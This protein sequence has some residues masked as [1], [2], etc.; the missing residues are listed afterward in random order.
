LSQQKPIIKE[1]VMDIDSNMNN[2][3]S[4]IIEKETHVEDEVV[5]PR[6][7]EPLNTNALTMIVLVPPVGTTKSYE[8]VPEKGMEYF[9]FFLIIS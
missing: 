1:N 6:E 4:P 2:S 5:Q 9:P 8:L 3:S 7:E